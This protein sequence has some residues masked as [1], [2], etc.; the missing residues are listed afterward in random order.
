MMKILVMT[1]MMMM[2]VIVVAA[3]VRDDENIDD[4]DDDGYCDRFLDFQAF[5]FAYRYGVC[6]LCTL[7]RRY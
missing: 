3:A 5:G 2:M 6:F 1:M 7:N 4:G